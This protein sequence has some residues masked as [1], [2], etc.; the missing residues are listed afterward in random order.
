M[1]IINESINRTL[2][3]GARSTFDVHFRF[4]NINKTLTV[5]SGE[6]KSK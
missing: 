2:I 6:K 1:D 4:E 3:I 5:A